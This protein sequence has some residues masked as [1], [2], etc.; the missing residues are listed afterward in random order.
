MLLVSFDCCCFVLFACRVVNSRRKKNNCN[1]TQRRASLLRAF[2]ASARV[3]AVAQ[4]APEQ[5]YK[6]LSAGVGALVDLRPE[7]DGIKI[8]DKVFVY[9]AEAILG[10]ECWR[11]RV[12][13]P[14]QRRFVLPSLCAGSC[15]RCA[16]GRCVQGRALGATRVVSRKISLVAVVHVVA[17]RRRRREWSATGARQTRSRGIAQEDH[18]RNAQCRQ[19]PR[20]RR[21][22]LGENPRGV[23]QQKSRPRE[24]NGV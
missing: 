20:Q 15:A 7:N 11:T 4:V 18:A 2:S 24:L 1:T 8:F 16:F 6:D 5:V 17:R 10:S 23:G 3:Q 22:L 14:L 9:P 13:A 12:H 21:V 19:V